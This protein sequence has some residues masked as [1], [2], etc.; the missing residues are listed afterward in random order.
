MDVTYATVTTASPLTVT[1]DSSDTA[2]PAAHLAAYTPVAADRVAVV[3][4]GH[5]QLVL[6]KVV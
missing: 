4:L 1:L 5:G 3:S 6:G 2:V